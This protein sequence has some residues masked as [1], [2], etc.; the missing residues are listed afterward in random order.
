MNVWFKRSVICLCIV[1]LITFNIRPIRASANPIAIGG[2]IALAPEVVVPLLIVG[3]VYAGYKITDTYKETVTKYLLEKVYNLGSSVKD[4]VSTYKDSKGQ[5]YAGLTDKGYSFSKETFSS[6]SKNKIE[7]EKETTSN[8]T[9]GTSS[10]YMYND[11]LMHPMSS[12]SKIWEDFY[13][14]WVEPGSEITFQSRS[15]KG[16]Y[17]SYKTLKIPND[18]VALNNSVKVGLYVSELYTFC[19]EYSLDGGKTFPKN[20]TFS[21]DY[22]FELSNYSYWGYSVN[23]TV[24][25]PGSETLQSGIEQGIVQGSTV[26][27]PISGQYSDSLEKTVY[28]PIEGSVANPVSGLQSIEGENAGTGEN[29]GTGE[30]T[31]TDSIGRTLE[32]IKDKVGEIARNISKPLDLDIP[33]SSVPTLDFSPL[34]VATQKFPFSI[35]WD[36]WNSV[37]LFSGSSTTFSYEFTE[38]KAFN[39]SITVLPHFKIDFADYPKADVCVKVFRLLELLSFIVFLIIKTRELIRG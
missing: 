14:F 22:S 12:P 25:V 8:T 2:A 30:G 18:I 23:K 19:W 38:V 20:G 10:A 27:V 16:V 11:I 3:G 13:T 31:L 4:Y 32:N 29:S 9:A 7:I 39:N 24:F 34:E 5:V 37:K 28:Y 35:P 17:D 33:S 6:I 36:L 21:G 1:G 15:G 26:A